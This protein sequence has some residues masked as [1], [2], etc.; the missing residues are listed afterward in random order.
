[1]TTL[2]IL[3]TTEAIA[4]AQTMD[5]ASFEKAY[6]TVTEWVTIENVFNLNEG[7]AALDFYGNDG[8]VTL[9]FIDGTFIN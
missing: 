8:K 9:E 4:A 2:I 5:C 7:Y 6:Q 1:M 3:T